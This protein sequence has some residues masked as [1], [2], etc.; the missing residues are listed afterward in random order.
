ML[1]KPGITGFFEYGDT[2]LEEGTYS[3]FRKLCYGFRDERWELAGT[4][5]GEDTNYYYAWWNVEGEK[6]YLLRNKYYDIYA[7][8]KGLQQNEKVFM[9]PPEPFSQYCETV[10][11][12]ILNEPWEEKEISLL[13]KAE[14]EQIRYWKPLSVGNIIFNEW[15]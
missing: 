13:A 10:S 14:L 4:S 7:F 3:E 1:L 6:R 5:Q 2:I 12:D 11:A 15:D 9:D 8:T